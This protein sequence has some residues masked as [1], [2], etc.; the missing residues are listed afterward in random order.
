MNQALHSISTLLQRG[1]KLIHT[2]HVYTCTYEQNI[3]T[4]Q[5]SKWLN[6]LQFSKFVCVTIYECLFWCSKNKAIQSMEIWMADYIPAGGLFVGGFTKTWTSAEED[7]PEVS[8]TLRTNVYI[9]SS[10]FESWR[11]GVRVF[12][13]KWYTFHDMFLL[14]QMWYNQTWRDH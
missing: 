1:N 11:Y 9:P 4:V 13:K 2:F 14:Q 5:Q 8:V 10:K 12:Y 3:T 6:S 7:C